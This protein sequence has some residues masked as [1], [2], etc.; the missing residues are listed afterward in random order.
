MRGILAPGTRWGTA[1]RVAIAAG[2]V[3]AG[4]IA[5]TTDVTSYRSEDGAQL[6]LY[7][8][9]VGIEHDAR[10]GALDLHVWACAENPESWLNVRCPAW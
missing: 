5:S 9:P 6:G 10:Q 8:G 3:L 1:Y 2:L 4:L 7:V